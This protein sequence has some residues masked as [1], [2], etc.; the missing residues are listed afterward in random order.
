VREEA[1][2]LFVETCMLVNLTFRDNLLSCASKFTLLEMGQSENTKF[3]E[4]VTILTSDVILRFNIGGYLTRECSVTGDS[5]TGL[6][7]VPICG[8]SSSSSM[9]HPK[10]MRFFSRNLLL[11]SSS[12]HLHTS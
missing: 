2:K 8:V 4:E 5:S 1:V 9:S 12:Q 3:K 6:V 10:H 7:F 11:F